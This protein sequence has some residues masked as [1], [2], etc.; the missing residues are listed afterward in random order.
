MFFLIELAPGRY[1]IFDSLTKHM[2]SISCYDI[3]TTISNFSQGYTWNTTTQPS[4]HI[5]I[6]ANRLID[7]ITTSPVIAKAKKLHYFENQ[8]PELFI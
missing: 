7:G 5:H 6:K 3:P 4:R 8:F 2:S 1:I